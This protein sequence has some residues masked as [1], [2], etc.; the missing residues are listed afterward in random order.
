MRD[1]A[2]DKTSGDTPN[3][4]DITKSSTAV[5]NDSKA[6][7]STPASDS[8]KGITI[9]S[10]KNA[11]KT[12]MWWKSLPSW[13]QAVDVVELKAKEEAAKNKKEDWWLDTSYKGKSFTNTTAA[14]K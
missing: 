7:T 1:G 5:T 3:K 14:K 11:K 10:S 9:T 6:S 12:P 4:D 8:N 2:N 13:V